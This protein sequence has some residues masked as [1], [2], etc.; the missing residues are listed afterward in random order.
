MVSA[1]HNG[2]G[3]LANTNENTGDALDATGSATAVITG[4]TFMGNTDYAFYLASGGVIKSTGGQY[5]IGERP[6]GDLGGSLT[7]LSKQ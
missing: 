5:G 4:S 3:I 7:S 6:R 1:G 2:Y